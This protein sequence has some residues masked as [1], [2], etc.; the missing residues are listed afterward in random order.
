MGE[1]NGNHMHGLQTAEAIHERRAIAEL[2]QRSRRWPRSVPENSQAGLGSR[3]WLLASPETSGGPH[4]SRIVLR[5][6]GAHC[7]EQTEL[8]CTTLA[9]MTAQ[10]RDVSYQRRN[11]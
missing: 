8:T 11:Q 2:L 5:Q 7:D 9:G 10:Q 3:S 4:P 6:R 1:R